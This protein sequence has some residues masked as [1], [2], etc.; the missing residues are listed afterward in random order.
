MSTHTMGDAGLAHIPEIHCPFPYRVNPHADRA[1]AHL[2]DWVQRTGLVHRE[3]ARKRFDQADFGWFAALVYPTASLRHLE[4]MADWFAWLFL[5]DDQLDDGSA[6]R[7]P[8]RMQQMVAGMHDVL[9]SPDFG[10]SLLCDPDV[11]PAVASLAELWQR[12][13]VDAPAH[14]RRRF[15]RHLRDCL[16]TATVWEGGNR[17]RGIVPDEVTY[18]EN[19]RHTGAIYV[20]MDLID[21]VERLDVPEELYDSAEFTRALDAAC[22]VVCWTNDVYSLDKERSLGEVHNIAYLA[23]YHRG[24]DREQALAEV[25]AATS[26]ETER[27]L[28]A[29]RHLLSA[30]PGQSAVLTPYLAGMR[31]WIRGNLDW[32]R[33]TKR[34]QAGTAVSWARPA[35]YVERALIGVDQ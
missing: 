7:S 24:L 22:N 18:I 5:V 6:G 10:V 11:P 14:W 23:Q 34:Y 35:D 21:I 20:C 29:E 9:G 12:T 25:C 30:R 16:V 8:D 31:T 33:R 26:A 27:F 32:S 2:A 4:L 28:A 1:R 17:I 19:R 3:S 15:I 13:A